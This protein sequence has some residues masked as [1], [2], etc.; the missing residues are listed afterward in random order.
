ME[1]KIQRILQPIFELYPAIQLV[2]FFGSKASRTD[3]PQSD[4]DFACYFDEKDAKK[5]FA[6]KS[7]L[8]DKIGRAL[9]TDNID[10]VILN[11]LDKPEMKYEIITKGELIFEKEPF[12]I[13]VEPKILNE[14]FDFHSMLIRYN[15]TKARHDQYSST[16]K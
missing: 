15:L 6:I 5:I 14:Y 13:I 1:N 11:T 3:G 16:R 4:Y 12:K 7:H 2:Y 9:Y 8:I 10:V